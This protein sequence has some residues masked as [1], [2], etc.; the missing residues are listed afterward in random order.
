MR[1]T[2][3]ITAAARGFGGEEGQG[4]IRQYVDRGEE[5]ERRCADA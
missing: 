2:T 5:A 1:R 3:Q 4:K